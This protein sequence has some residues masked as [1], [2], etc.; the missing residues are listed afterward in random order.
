MS[1]SMLLLSALVIIGILIGILDT[2]LV[3]KKE[4]KSID[5]IDIENNKTAYVV[6]GCKGTDRPLFDVIGTYSTEP[7]ASE[8]VEKMMNTN[9]ERKYNH[10]E[11]IEA[12]MDE[13]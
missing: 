1:T 6:I 8:I 7:L 11:I 12:P 2:L 9:Q 13:K 4:T 3:M 5:N 10:I